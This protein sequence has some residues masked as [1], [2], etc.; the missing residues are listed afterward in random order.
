MPKK[1]PTRGYMTIAENNNIIDYI[2]L[3]YGLA[4]S[5]N[6]TQTD[7]KKISIGITPG[8]SVPDKYHQVFDEIIDLPWEDNAEYSHWK[9]ENRWKTYHITPYDETVLVDSDMLFTSD[10]GDW[11]NIMS[12]KSFNPTTS[13]KTYR[14]EDVTDNYYRKAFIMNNLPNIYTGFMF[15][16]RNNKA[17]ELFDL[18]ETI[19]KNWEKFYYEFLDNDV[20]GYVSADVVFGI[21]TKILGMSDEL[22]ENN[23]CSIPT[24]VH[25]KSQVQ[26]WNLNTERDINWMGIV[27]S[28]VTPNLE[29][30]IAQ[31]KQ[32]LPFHYH[33]KKFLTDEIIEIYEKK[34]G[35]S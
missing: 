4:L 6:A 19:F 8:T 1:N 17:Q 31:Y 27:P 35:I 3:A 23:A 16:K 10:I 34:L 32:N 11:W 28:F 2:R 20:P 29:I 9:V 12:N 15:F 22:F 14:N 24:F 30:K 18:V 13:V 21:A 33:I 26:K 5:I 25:M 7:V